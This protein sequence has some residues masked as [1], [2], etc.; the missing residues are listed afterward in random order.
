MMQMLAMDWPDLPDRIGVLSTVRAGGVSTGSYGAADGS[1]GGLNLGLHVGD[2]PAA[3]AQNRR[4]LRAQ[5][6]AEP[7]WLSQVHGTRVLN[8]SQSPCRPP[9]PTSAP[10]EADASIAAQPAQIC[11][12]MT[13]DCLPVLLAD[14]RGSH[15]GAAHAGWRGLAQDVIAQTVAAMR[16]AGADELTAWLGP[17]IGPRAFEVGGEVREAFAHWGSEAMAAFAPVPAK[18]DKFFADLYQ[19]ARIA[20]RRQ[21]VTSVSGGAHCTVGDPTRFY[22]FRRDGVTGRMASLIWIK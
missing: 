5:L 17:A 14:R 13:A 22:S 21:G 12:I 7:A 8:L 4:L 19:L 18:G 1:G 20:L 2:D 15:V 6:L 11:T 9:D 10:P 3:V 16:A